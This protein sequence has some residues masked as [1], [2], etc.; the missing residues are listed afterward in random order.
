MN[1]KGPFD[2]SLPSSNGCPSDFQLDAFWLEGEPA[3]HPLRCHLDAC[4]RCQQRIASHARVQ[5]EFRQ[6]VYPGSVGR[7][8]AALASKWTGFGRGFLSFAW[9]GRFAGAV[10]FGGLLVLLML[11]FW[12]SAPRESERS[13][14]IGIKGT[15]GL[16]VFC[17][18]GEQVFRVNQG[19]RLVPGDMLRFVP[20]LPGPGFLLVVSV[21][22]RGGL[23]VYYPLGGNAALSAEPGEHP[24]PKSVVL[25]E[26]GGDER[27]FALF[28]DKP[29]G[30]D[31][32]SQSVS[33]GWRR[34][35]DLESLA[36]LPMNVAQTSILFHK[37]AK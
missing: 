16:Q 21:N 3:G 34:T 29:F 19:D 18:R 32:V 26:V 37:R 17:R 2:L 8:T 5:D 14:Y 22:E 6:T 30:L 33:E 28:S 10:A 24:L 13:T 9:N 31:Q 23:N 27:I 1:Q 7:V 4:A 20:A 12:P 11:A 15:L 36:M 35:P 25:D